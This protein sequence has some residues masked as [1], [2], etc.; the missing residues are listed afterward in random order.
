MNRLSLEEQQCFLSLGE[1]LGYLDR[2]MQV[3]QLELLEEEM[4]DRIKALKA[5]MPQ[6]KKLYQSMGIPFGETLR[7]RRYFPLHLHIVVCFIARKEV[8]PCD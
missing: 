8:T 7:S 4:R 1:K 6:K 2:E 3:G 5:A